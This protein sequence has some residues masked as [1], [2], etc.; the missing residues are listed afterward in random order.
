MRVIAGRFRGHP[1]HA[2]AGTRTRP[3]SDRV[4][5]ALFAVLGDVTGRRVLDLFS[6]TGALGIEALSR[7]AAHVTFVEVWRPA[8]M[9]LEQ[10]VRRV[11]VVDEATVLALRVDRARPRLLEMGPF[12]L[13]FADPPW[14]DL[15]PT[16]STLSRV[17]AAPVA[18]PNGIIV[19]EHPSRAP[20]PC[21][22]SL[23]GEPFD[24]RTYGDTSI[25]LFRVESL[26]PLA[27][28]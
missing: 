1:L 10:N 5:E 17:L 25:S 23:A 22:P 2:P 26:G 16:C 11:G 15:H 14:A 9:V 13:I 8:R 24:R 19:L 6:G 27:V 12:D 3:T 21:L 18:A 28:S 7:G 20:G 4:R